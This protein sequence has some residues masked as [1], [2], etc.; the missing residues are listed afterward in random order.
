MT[1]VVSGV[2]DSSINKAEEEIKAQNIEE[3]SQTELEHKYV[4]WVTMRAQ[5]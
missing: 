5:Q 1:E 3:E 2:T 4:F